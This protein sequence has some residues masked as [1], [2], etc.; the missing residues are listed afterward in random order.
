M[1][2]YRK[3]GLPSRAPNSMN[4]Y[5]LVLNECHACKQQKGRFLS[6]DEFSER[7]SL[8]F[9]FQARA[10]PALD[11]VHFCILKTRVQGKE[12]AQVGFQ[13]RPKDRFETCL[14]RDSQRDP[15]P[16]RRKAL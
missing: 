1:Q 12:E 5:G 9:G 4:N 8:M 15:P 14:F 11:L 6:N 7:D 13:L 10:L 3:S 16:H 2:N